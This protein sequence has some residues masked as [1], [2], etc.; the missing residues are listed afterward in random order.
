MVPA[1]SWLTSRLYPEITILKPA[2]SATDD[3]WTKVQNAAG[4]ILRY[5]EGIGEAYLTE[6]M[7]LLPSPEQESKLSMH[8]A[9]PPEELDFLA[10]AD[11][12]LIELLKIDHLRA[13][14]KAMIYR[15]RFVENIARLED[16]AHKV[17]RASKA[18]LDAPHFSELLKVR[19]S[20]R[21][22]EGSFQ[23]TLDF[24][25]QLILMLGNFLNASNHKGNAQGFKVTSINK[26]V[27]T[28]S[29][30]SS[31][32]TLLHFTAQTITQTMP[33]TEAFL[34]ELVQPA[35]AF[36]GASLHCRDGIRAKTDLGAISAVDLS[37]VRSALIDFTTHQEGLNNLL[38]THFE[39]LAQ[40]SPDDG[41]PKKM[42]RF[43]REAEERIAALKDLL[44]LADSTYNQ[45][46]VFYGEDA[47]SIASTDEFFS[48]FKTFITS[49]RSAKED[50]R[51]AE[52]ARRK[53]EEA[54]V[55]VHECPLFKRLTDVFGHRSQ[56][57]KAEAAAAAAAALQ[58]GDSLVEDM[59][60]SLRDQSLNTPR[61]VRRDRRKNQAGSSSSLSSPSAALGGSGGGRGDRDGAAASPTPQVVPGDRQGLDNLL[62]SGQEL[63]ARLTGEGVRRP[64]CVSRDGA[65]C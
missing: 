41:F 43:R 33:E 39:D 55:S 9:T 42:F 37:H 34:D 13:R 3:P 15:E 14:L 35:E 32:R 8:K 7:A 40:L 6:L 54:A 44:R 26:L 1:C 27:D 51:R 10:P 28:K 61:A 60:K 19:L 56:A 21:S 48:V 25:L 4:R 11:R 62:A 2:G 23:L 52:D 38:S 45:A 31:S 17:Y 59:M 64:F 29:S 24:S 18:L 57:R 65:G 46:L 58:T 16:D 53:A 12:F 22:A 63:M 30:K 49:Y 36:K 20:D 5:D 47:K 50:N